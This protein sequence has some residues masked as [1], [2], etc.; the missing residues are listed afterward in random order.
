[1]NKYLN[2]DRSGKWKVAL[3]YL[4]LFRSFVP[5]VKSMYV[6]TKTIQSRELYFLWNRWRWESVGEL[7]CPASLSKPCLDSNVGKLPSARISNKRIFQRQKIEHPRKLYTLFD[8]TTSITIFCNYELSKALKRP[9]QNLTPQV[10][11]QS[12]VSVNIK[13]W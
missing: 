12:K 6:R 2:S 10:S 4:R 3:S 11:S 9:A 8:S 7:S 13:S 1:M 5:Y